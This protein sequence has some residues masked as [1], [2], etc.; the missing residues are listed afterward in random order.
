MVYFTTVE[1]VTFLFLFCTLTPPEDVELRLRSST[2]PETLK[3]ELD[4]PS[5]MSGPGRF[6][7]L[8]QTKA[9]NDFFNGEIPTAGFRINERGER[10]ATFAELQAA[11]VVVKQDGIVSI[12]QYTTDMQSSDWIDRA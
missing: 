10:E 7:S 1:S 5:Y 9:V 11:G 12:S 4:L 2:A 6:A 3:V 8:F